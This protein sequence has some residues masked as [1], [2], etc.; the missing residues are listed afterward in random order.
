MVNP[1]NFVKK[2]KEGKLRVNQ[3]KVYNT[4]TR[5]HQ[6]LV[7]KKSPNFSLINIKTK[8]SLKYRLIDINSKWIW[9]CLQNNRYLEYL[10]LFY[11][12]KKR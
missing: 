11:Q 3:Q 8:V 6:I 4:V 10:Y 2:K 5:N 7:K 9:I 1:L 12:S